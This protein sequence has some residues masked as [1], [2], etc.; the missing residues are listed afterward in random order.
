MKKS[1]LFWLGLFS[2]GGLVL[3][4]WAI[5]LLGTKKKIFEQTFHL[6]VPFETVAGLREGSP[7]R[8]SGIDV[9]VVEK[10][11]LPAAPGGKVVVVMRLDQ[12][13]QQ[14]I[15]KDAYAVIETEGLV[16]NR[17]VSIKG[18]SL[19]QLHV[20]DEDSI[21]S[22]SPIDLSAILVSFDETAR[23]MQLVTASLDGIT[24]KIR[25]GEG[26]IGKL[27]YDEEFYRNLVSMTDRSDSAFAAA[28]A[29]TRRLGDL[30]TKVSTAT[31]SIIQRVEAGE[32]TLGALVYKDDLY[33]LTFETVSN[34]RDS[35]TALLHDMRLGQGVV[36]K[37]ISDRELAAQL[38][39]SF[40]RL[41][42][43][44]QEL[45]ELS[46]VARAG[47]FSF[48]ENMEALKHNWLFKGYFERR[49]FWSRSEFEK[50]YAE[51]EREIAEREARLEEHEKTLATQYQQLQE[52]HKQVQK[53]LQQAEELERRQRAQNEPEP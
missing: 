35:L 31:D 14:L 30:L 8:L 51:R 29:E 5:F 17:I 48:A 42:R 10:I 45:S 18:G 19:G 12:G 50:R 46:R 28:S 33:H 40:N 25:S 21:S 37:L 11:A 9:G 38:D 49:G 22:R 53:R 24:S 52:L 2:F 47:A 4:V 44:N 41:A 26:T 1:R 15:R 27:V 3:L 36:G 7:V 32:G 43:L 34:T 13:V 23:Y 39:S 6:L 16:G 20:S